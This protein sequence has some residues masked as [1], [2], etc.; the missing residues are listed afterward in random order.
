MSMHVSRGLGVLAWLV[1]P[2]YIAFEL[3]VAARARGLSLRSATISDLGATVCST[4]TCSPWHAA[5]NASFVLTGVLFAAGALL[6]RPS[7]PP[8]RLVDL[9]VLLWVLAGV[10]SVA[11][12]L[13]PVNEN[14]ALHYAVAAPLFLLQ[15]VSLL[16]AG[17]ALWPQ[18]RALASFTLL[19]AAG[20][21]VATVLF[22]AV[23]AAELDG[24]LERLALW[25]VKVVLG[26][27]AISMLT[28]RPRGDARK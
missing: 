18:A 6:L 8:G 23:P 17:W 2:A 12:G 15:P 9:A 26:V 1:Q 16:L 24:L 27:L 19:T 14:P 22:V 28:G 20:C 5:L 13:M 25:P 11:T 7:L 4:A 10:S 3:A 21:A